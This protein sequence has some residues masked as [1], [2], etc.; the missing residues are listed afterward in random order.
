MG[1]DPAVRKMGSDPKYAAGWAFVYFF[2]LL[3]G[4]YVLRPIRDELAIQGGQAELSRLFTLVFVS[5]LVLV[6]IF[7]WLTSRIPRKRL[8]PWLYAFFVANLL[9]FYA[10]FNANGVQ[11]RDLAATFF[12]WV[13]VFNLFAV[14]LF[15]SFMADLFDTYQAKRLYGIISAGGTA[16]ALA[17]P[18]LTAL[19]VTQVGAK[20]ML[21]VS[22][23]FLVV[24]IIAILQLRAWAA[25]NHAQGHA[26]TEAPLGGGMWQGIQDVVRSPY[27]L[28]I[29]A[30]LLCYTL[31]STFLYFAQTDLFP[32]AVKSSAE[33]TRLLALVDLAV[34][35]LALGLQLVA[36][37]ALM[38]KLGTTATLTAMPIVA[39]VG[40]TAL[41]LSPVLAVLIA[42]GIVRRAGEYAIS[43]PARETLYNVLPAEQKYKA[44]NV[45]DTVVHRGGDTASSWIFNGARALGFSMTTMAWI[46][47]PLS[48]V[49]LGGALWLGRAARAR[50]RQAAEGSADAEAGAS[51][52]AASGVSLDASVSR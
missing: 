42:F 2:A 27:L 3:A 46:A 47:V 51:P 19:F 35:V 6:P 50:Q 20:G 49:W 10:A 25:R 38:Q 24:A 30:F 16:G 13:S 9:G 39:I 44:K 12:V 17:G 5:M 32:A 37:K 8:L 22:A 48:C 21:L 34:N 4:Y 45:I 36:F 15:W 28:G 7:G 43:K 52:A 31:L 1:S 11:P 40:F 33:R 26:E 14:S 41:A 18:S 23:G 29:C